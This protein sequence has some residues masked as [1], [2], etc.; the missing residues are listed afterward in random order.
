MGR[1]FAASGRLAGVSGESVGGSQKAGIQEIEQRPQIPKT[2]FHGVPIRARRA[3]AFRALRALLCRAPGF[4]AA[5]ASS[6]MS[7][8]Q[9]TSARKACRASLAQVGEG[10]VA[11]GQLCLGILGQARQAPAAVNGPVKKARFQSG[12]GSPAGPL[13]AGAA[14][15]SRPPEGR[16]PDI[17][18]RQWGGAAATGSASKSRGGPARAG[19][20]SGGFGLPF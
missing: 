2:V 9:F 18:R 4:L 17:R 14:A 5:C 11:T 8:L 15:N 1:L 3:L 13:P 16:L 12:R 19:K 10:Q 20:N 7:R 6:A